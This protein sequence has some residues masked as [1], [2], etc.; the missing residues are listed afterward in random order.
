MFMIKFNPT[1]GS[2]PSNMVKKFSGKS[3]IGIGSMYIDIA[4]EKPKTYD[5]KIITKDVFDKTISEYREHFGSENPENFE[6]WSNG[7]VEKA[8]RCYADN[9]LIED[10]QNFFS[11][12]SK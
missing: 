5:L 4:S 11:S 10:I 2:Q 7:I 9:S 1:F 12:I 6:M 8:K 3:N